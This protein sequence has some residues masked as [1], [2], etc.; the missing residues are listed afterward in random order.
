LRGGE[1]ARSLRLFSPRIPDFYLNIGRTENVKVQ[2]KIIIC[3]Y[4]TF[5]FL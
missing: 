1:K 4:W 3:N 5:C 2:I